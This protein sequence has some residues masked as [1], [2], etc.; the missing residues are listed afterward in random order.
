MT[1]RS[2]VITAFLVAF[3]VRQAPAQPPADAGRESHVSQGRAAL[4]AHDPTKAIRH[5]EQADTAESQAWLA[6]A[7]M[8]E[9]R[10]PSDAYVERA[11]E[12]AGSARADQRA[13]TPTR[14]E[15]AATLNPG[16]IVIAFLVGESRAYGWAFDREAFVGYELPPPGDIATA[17]D[18]AVA[19]SEHDD[20]EGLQRI[21]E[22]LMPA[23]L[24]PAIERLPKLTRVFF[25]LDG[26]LQRLPIGALPVGGK[27][28]P[29]SQQVAVS[30]AARGSLIDQIK[31]DDSRAVAIQPAGKPS[32]TL[33]GGI[34]LTLLLLA[35]FA[36]LRRR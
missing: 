16:D 27:G 13:R 12:A 24:G 5:F 15:I 3:I 28:S 6:M 9:S 23:L 7:L 35:G 30:I 17:V 32:S 36:V 26:P 4:A 21:A 29:L 2:A 10:S 11:F 14:A 34:V 33:I 19:Y 8:M 20:R 31:R 18:R 25:V 22:E 1:R